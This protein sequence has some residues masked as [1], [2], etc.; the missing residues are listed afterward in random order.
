[1]SY[2]K[3]EECDRC[4]HAHLTEKLFVLHCD[5]MN[6]EVDGDEA[7]NEFEDRGYNIF[8]V[9]DDLRHKLP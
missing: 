9:D 1:M 7:C 3:I 2:R 8:C 4:V 6:E 5:I